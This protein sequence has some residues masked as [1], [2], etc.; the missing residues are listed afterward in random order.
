[1]KHCQ[2]GC[3]RVAAVHQ[4]C[5]MLQPAVMPLTLPQQSGK[6]VFLLHANQ[7]CKLALRRFNSWLQGLYDGS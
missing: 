6:A 1:M 4:D 3:S 5:H 7:F 2:A